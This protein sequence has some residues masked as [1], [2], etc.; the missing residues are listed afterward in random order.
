MVKILSVFGILLVL[1][2]NVAYCNN[3][4][5]DKKL[6]LSGKKAFKQ[7]KLN[8]LIRL[9]NSSSNEGLNQ[10]FDFWSIKLK[11]EKNPF[12]KSIK[13]DLDKF[14]KQKK[15]KFLAKECYKYWAHEI[16]KKGNWEKE[17]GKG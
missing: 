7:K 15:L 16:I 9:K 1:L 6:I 4:V 3:S 12:D 8:K 14:S 11:I 13:T 5:S 2:P 17:L 10:W